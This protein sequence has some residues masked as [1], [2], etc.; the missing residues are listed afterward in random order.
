MKNNI[1]KPEKQTLASNYDRNF[2]DAL[3]QYFRKY[4]KPGESFT[5]K[6]EIT[7]ELAYLCTKFADANQTIAF[8]LEICVKCEENEITNPV[9]ALDHATAALQDIM[10][11][12]FQSERISHISQSWSEYDFENI[13]ILAKAT[14]ASPYLD[15]LAD[16]FLKLHG[17]SPDAEPEES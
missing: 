7:H 12:Y 3:K 10:L 16:E 2:Q 1:D 11:D 6:S 8:E 13:K 17:Y 15:N 14:N 4:I 9:D 5:L